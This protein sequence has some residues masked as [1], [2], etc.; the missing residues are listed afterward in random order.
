MNNFGFYI[1]EASKLVLKEGKYLVFFL[2]FSGILFAVMFSIPLYSIPGNDLKLQIV[3]FKPR[4][5]V[6][7]GAL[8]LLS[9]LVV[10]IQ[11]NIFR[12][13]LSSSK[14]NAAL[15]GVGVFSGV[16]S[17]IFASATCALC[18]GSL[19]SFLGFGGVLFLVE[20]RWYILSAATVLLLISL[21][22]ASKRLI[23]G[24]QSCIIEERV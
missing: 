7:L 21:Y 8:S 9:S 23:D 2:V 22:F 6:L 19:F 18:L 17:S 12:Q 1:F 14:S 4:D 10:T 13:K 16:L 3:L 20:N 11:V 15:G 5:Y 24:C